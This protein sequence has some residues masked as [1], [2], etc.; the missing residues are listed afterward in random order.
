M[1]DADDAL[2]AEDGPTPEHTPLPGRGRST[3]H[4]PRRHLGYHRLDTG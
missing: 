4:T 1:N 3:T 2:S